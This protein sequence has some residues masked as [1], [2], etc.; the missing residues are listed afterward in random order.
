VAPDHPWTTTHPH[1]FIQ[2]SD[3]DARNAPT[4]YIEVGDRVLA[5]GRD[6]YFPAW[7]DVLQLN[8]FQP[9]LR[10]A[11]IETLLDIAGQCDGVRCDMAMLFL[12]QVFESTWGDRAGERPVTEYWDDVVA[13]VKGEHPNFLFM[14]EV[15]WELEWELMRR[16]FD[17]CYDKRLYDRLEHDNAECVRLHLCAEL[18]YQRKLVRF[19]EN[20]DE[21]RAH[22]A[23]PPGKERAAAVIMSTL[24]GAKLIH[25]GQCDGR[26]IR[27]P[28]FLRRRPSEAIDADLR[29]FYDKLCTGANLAGVRD[30]EWRLCE[31]FGWPDNGT[32][33]HLLA[34]CWQN[35]DVRL[36]TIVNLS[37]SN[38][39]GRILLPWDDLKGIAW[40]T[41]DILSGQV[42]ERN[43]D[44]MCTQGLYVDLPPW[45][46]HVLSPWVRLAQQSDTLP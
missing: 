43:G 5:C 10:H 21:P 17:Y 25:E 15:Y 14:A 39:Q 9:G 41:T 27:L 38:A 31:R 36:L 40:R 7:P 33:E 20:H 19:I 12:N 2:G 18:V 23:F 3:E 34:S 4:S 37:D 6:P 35:G 46:F 44:E 28:V 22:S 32:Y 11:V 45:G 29:F 30:G 8:A 13:T 26:R 42:F 16:G 1:Y 24:P